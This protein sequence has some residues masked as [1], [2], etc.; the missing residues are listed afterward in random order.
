[1]DK[2]RR[3]RLTE[4]DHAAWASYASRITPLPGRKRPVHVEIPA[5]ADAPPAGS[6]ARA[7]TP[8]PRPG[9]HV[10]GA[11]PAPTAVTVGTQPG[12]V[13]NATW[14]RLRTG[15]LR[16]ARILDLH[17][18]TAQ[19]AYHALAAFLRTAHADRLRCVEVVTGRGS[20]EGGVLRREL[21]L[22]LN[23]PE[24]RPLVL[25]ASHPHSANPGSVRLLLRRPR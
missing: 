15:K 23:L 11:H 14:Q 7:P 16:G 5:T 10:R 19:R 24:I 17:G 3:S 21:P 6:P 20:L 1:M 18:Q 25:A 13:D 2:P 9:A 8:R 4:A 12:G 22:W